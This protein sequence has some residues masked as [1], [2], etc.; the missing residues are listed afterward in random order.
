MKK[1]EI[2]SAI[3]LRHLS[4]SLALGLTAASLSGCG[5]HLRGTQTSAIPVAYKN[6]Q[7]DLPQQAA[8]LREPLVVYLQ[9]LGAMVNQD[10]TAPIIKITDYQQTRQ[11][12]SGRLT[13][14]QLRLAIT[15]HIESSLGEP[16]TIDYSVYSRRS[17]QYDIATVNTENQEEAHLIEEMNLD[18]AM[19]IAR[20][21][22]AGR[23][24]YATADGKKTAP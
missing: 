1:P 12:L 17:Y 14:V 6:V 21:L 19:Q 3:T 20:Q 2:L 9:S 5:F 13:E 16:L 15:Y 7:V 23:M 10:K 11:L 18:A 24:Q 22:H 8:A 4:L